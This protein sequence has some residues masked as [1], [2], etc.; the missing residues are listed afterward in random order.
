MPIEQSQILGMDGPDTPG[1]RGMAGHASRDGRGLFL[2]LLAITCGQGLTHIAC[3][4][5]TYVILPDGSSG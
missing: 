2:A 5:Y 3:P 1:S 4:D